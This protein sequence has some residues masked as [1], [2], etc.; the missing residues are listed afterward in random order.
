MHTVKCFIQLSQKILLHIHTYTDT[1]CFKQLLLYSI[2]PSRDFDHLKKKGVVSQEKKNLTLVFSIKGTERLLW[3]RCTVTL[4]PPVHK[5]E[6]ILFIIRDI[7]W[8]C[9]NKVN[10]SQIF[11]VLWQIITHKIPNYFSYVLSRHW[12]YLR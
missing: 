7:A 4:N 5:S 1:G 10:H 8:E 11:D 6:K 2:P 3:G 9:H 12:L